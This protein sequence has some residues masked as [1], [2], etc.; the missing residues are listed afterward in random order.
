MTLRVSQARVRYDARAQVQEAT[1]L[2][3]LTSI[4]CSACE[5]VTQLAGVAT[6]GDVVSVMTVFAGV[7]GAG[8]PRLSVD[9]GDASGG[10]GVHIARC[11]AALGRVRLD[12]EVR[13]R[14]AHGLWPTRLSECATACCVL[15][16]G[17]TEFAMR[18]RA[19]GRY[20]HASSPRS[21]HR[22]FGRCTQWR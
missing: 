12:D 13:W 22:A 14:G 15:L 21:S 9:G 11:F 20:C 19:H 17:R 2:E 16:I 6:P 7:C 4:F 8:S 1:P 5:V 18:R 3:A 10:V